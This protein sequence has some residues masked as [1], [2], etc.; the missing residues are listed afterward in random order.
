MVTHAVARGRKA[1]EEMDAALRGKPSE[2][3]GAPAIIKP[4]RM[5]L[6]WYPASPRHE[7]ADASGNLSA[8]DAIAEAARCMSCGKCMD[9]ETC[10][11]YC[12]NNCFVKL[13]KGEHYRIRLELCNGCG[14]CVDACPCGYIEAN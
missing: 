11:M 1:A 10:W 13:P 3:H 5:K 6:D 12:S 2:S 7:A 9:C 4:A 14:K 8:E